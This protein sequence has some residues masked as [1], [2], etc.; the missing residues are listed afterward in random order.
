MSEMSRCQERARSERRGAETQPRTRLDFPPGG[1][2][3]PDG[4]PAADSSVGGASSCCPGTAS[5]SA[6]LFSKGRQGEQGQTGESAE[7]N[8]PYN[9]IIVKMVHFAGK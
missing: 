8:N 5:G 6:I 3:R 2:L 1:F 9:V 4:I 7:G